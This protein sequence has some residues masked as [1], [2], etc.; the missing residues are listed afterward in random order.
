MVGLAA[1]VSLSALLAAC[2]SHSGGNQPAQLTGT[3][4]ML[5]NITPVLTKDYYQGLVAPYV[6]AHPG[7]TV[8]IEAPTGQGVAD[9]LQQEIAAG[10]PADIISGGIPTS[11]ANL[12]VEY[13]NEK[14]VTDTPFADAGKVNGKIWSIG[15]GVQIQS[16]VFYN[17]AAF[18]KA[19]ITTLPKSVD[20]FTA[21]LT[22]LKA[23]GYVP[24]QT[25][26]EWVTGYQFLMMA[27][28]TALA[29]DPNWYAERNKGSVKFAESNYAPYLSAYE[30]WIKDGLV[31][32][33][34]PAIK[35][36]DAIDE[37]TSGKS[38]T[39][40][41]GN[42]LVPSV[43]QVTKNF[44]VGAFPVPT[45][46]GAPGP[47]AGNPSMPYSITKASKNQALALDLVKYL[48]SDKDAVTS[49]LKVE[50]N[51]RSGY[52]YSASPLSQ[53]VG[54][55]LDQNPG[56]FVVQGDGMGDNSAPAGFGTELGTEIQG[57]YLGTPATSV[58][59]SI[60]KWWTSNVK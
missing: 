8:T 50:G 59:G 20:E 53:E 3:V 23:A 42:W 15:S 49:Q 47:V 48:V 43:D 14:W 51:F 32:K 60:D 25:A 29:N 12:M 33:D 9:T 58:I 26:G 2:S 13:P 7:V 6:Q 56:Q 17:K 24:L 54:A 30:G 34:A 36:Q 19:G 28:P 16:L 55:I 4:R 1:A 22:L 38:A 40:V 10:N 57:M 37:F 46:S 11:V 45:L 21:D 35:Y 31:P 39:F 52:S 27:N 41:M 18:A 44:E 5:V